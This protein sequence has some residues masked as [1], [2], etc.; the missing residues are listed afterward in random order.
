M[1]ALV[2]PEEF[3]G[4]VQSDLDRYTAE[5][6]LS[7]AS[8]LVRSYCRWR[9]SEETATLVADGTGTDL[10]SL[11]TLRLTDVTAVRIDGELLD[12]SAWSFSRNGQVRYVDGIW[13]RR[14]RAIEV[15]CTHGY[16]VTPDEIR[17]VVFAL[18]ARYYVNPQG[19]RSKT[20]GAVSRTFVLE[21][22]RGDLTEIETVLIAG[23]RLP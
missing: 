13:P 22:M 6:A 11:P 7:A 4:Y 23:Y 10:L 1:D 5:L 3:A 8:G 17:A 15:D 20:V 21:S 2:T 18:G 16:A 12:A 9:I 14:F 19:L